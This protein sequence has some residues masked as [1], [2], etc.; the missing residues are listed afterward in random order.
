[1]YTIKHAAEMI[2]VKVAT[3]RAWERR[4]GL[5]D[6][7]RT[8][9]GYRLYDDEN[10]RALS[11][12]NA[13]VLEGWAPKQAAEEAQR[14]MA[15]PR[16]DAPWQGDGAGATE[17]LLRAAE[18]LDVAAV[19]RLLDAQFASDSPEKVIDDWL[20]PSLQSLGL[21]WASGRV[22]VAGEHMVSHAVVR[23]LSATYEAAEPLGQ[24]PEVM[25]GLPPKSRHELGLLGFAVAARRVGLA[26]TYLGADLPSDEWVAVVESRRPAALV[27]AASMSRDLSRLA[28][29]VEAMRAAHPDLLIAVGGGLQDRTPEHCLR[30]GHRVGD[31]ARE[32]ASR[33]RTS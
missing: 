22:S 5:T 6:P 27:L 18:I 28:D 30:L 11:T 2:G 10:L 31:A 1:M 26:T 7:E 24:G 23:R 17:E 4:Y 19:T 14:R 13:L 25:I 12:M 32:L 16:L 20:L 8:D 15:E 9:A 21:A 33:L 3:L 29:V